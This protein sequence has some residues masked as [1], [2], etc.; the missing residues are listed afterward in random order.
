M[1]QNQN[2]QSQIK[3]LRDEFRDYRH[4]KLKIMHA[5]MENNLISAE[6]VSENID[7]CMQSQNESYTKFNS[8][9]RKKLKVV[10]LV[11]EEHT[12]N[13]KQRK[14]GGEASSKLFQCQSCTRLFRYESNLNLHA[15]SHVKKKNKKRR[16][17]KP[18][19]TYNIFEN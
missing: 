15:K 3:S 13:N 1:G 12:E 16:T 18:L 11:S 8:N 10:D 6:H 7:I 9:N 5:E 17:S 19:K 2:L 14:V 4:M